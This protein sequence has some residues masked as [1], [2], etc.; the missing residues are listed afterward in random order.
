MLFTTL[1][2]SK[3]GDNG[4]KYLA[5]R[6]VHKS[7]LP[8]V[9]SHAGY[10]TEEEMQSLRDHDHYISITPESE[11][12]HG[13]G[14]RT[15]SLISD[16]ASLGCDGNWTYSGDVLGQARLWLQ[17]VR[18]TTYLDTLEKGELPNR[19]PMKVEDAFLLATRQGG[20]ALHRSDIGVLKPGSKADIVVWN[21]ES[22]NMLGYKDP[23]AA[24]M[25]HAN[26]GDVE[27]VLV[28]GQWRKRD[29]KLVLPGKL[30]WHELKARFLEVAKR[31]QHDVGSPPPV[32]LE[33]FGKQLGDVRVS[34]AGQ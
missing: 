5:D 18:H 33:W 20:R 4:P 7:N 30:A 31:I 29:F 24:V 28:D 13:H 25:L 23:I 6:Q 16:H 15:G 22:P 17:T 3:V 8:L 9:F 27:H 32:P 12:H 2:W 10:L 1:M 11:F 34:S 21:G 26:V 14:Q 19:N